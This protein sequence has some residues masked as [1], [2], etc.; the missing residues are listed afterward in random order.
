MSKSRKIAHLLIFAVV[1]V[2]TYSINSTTPVGA[3]AGSAGGG[4]TNTGIGYF[5]S[6]GWGWYRYTIGTTDVPSYVNDS[7][8]S[9]VASAC[10]GYKYVIGFTLQNKDV[11]KKKAIWGIEDMYWWEPGHYHWNGD[12]NNRPPYSAYLGDSGG[13]WVS[14]STAKLRFESLPSAEKSGHYWT[15]SFF[16]N[17]P[18]A[19]WYC[20]EPISNWT[21]TGTTTVT[22]NGVSASTAKPGDTIFWNQTLI[23]NGPTASST[24]FSQTFGAG[25]FSIPGFEGLHDVTSGVMAAGGRRDPVSY[26]TYTVQASDGGKTL[27]QELQ[28]DPKNSSG[29]RDGRSSACVDIEYDFTITGSVSVNNSVPVPGDTVVWTHS[30]KNTGTTSTSPTSI[31]SST[32]GTGIFTAPEDVSGIRNSRSETMASGFERTFTQSYEIQAADGGKK[33]CQ[34]L[35]WHPIDEEGNGPSSAEKCVDVPFLHDLNPQKPTGLPDVALPDTNLTGISASVDNNGDTISPADTKAAVV[36]FVV[37]SPTDPPTLGGYT[38]LLDNVNYRC[39]IA[40]KLSSSQTEC[41]AIGPEYSGSFYPGSTAIIDSAI[42]SDNLALISTLDF[43]DHV[44]YASMVNNYEPSKG[45]LDWL[46][47]VPHCVA[48]KK[49]PTVHVWGNDVRVGSAIESADNADSKIQSLT[50]PGDSGNYFGSWSEYGAIA[51]ADILG[52]ASGAGLYGGNTNDP[53]DWSNLTFANTPSYGSFVADTNEWRLGTLPRIK[54]WDFSGAKIVTPSNSKYK[55]W[56]TPFASSKIVVVKGDSLRIDGD[57]EIPS[58][59]SNYASVAEMPQMII[60]ANN[61]LIDK[62]VNRIDAW[63]IASDTINTCAKGGPADANVNDKPNTN[64]CDEQLII[65]GPVIAKNLKLFRT[66]GAE[67]VAT[68]N[69]PAETINFSA[70]SYVWARHQAEQSGGLRTVAIRELPPRF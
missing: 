1:L 42:A 48:I 51:P 6:N 53:I 46:Y 5:S 43:G 29:G 24:I 13:N 2:F 27:C 8:W 70:D 61:I 58:A 67:S 39:Q 35:R 16:V 50:I 33:L 32:L 11:P 4:G 41:V 38:T 60:I 7:S 55:G 44:C 34:E 57:I 30:L 23:N 18:I 54:D 15:N 63:L 62:K 10:S 9:N 12:G 25:G 17:K 49:T 52:F 59:L 20:Y 36:R 3:V 28:W 68:L 19:S 65:N 37:P 40:E 45:D 56:E 21:T 31:Q 66:F 26:Q 22:V 14:W 69:D 47:S 64:Q